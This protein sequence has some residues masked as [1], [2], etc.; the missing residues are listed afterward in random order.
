MRPVTAGTAELDLA[1][2]TLTKTGTNLV[3]FVDGSITEPGTIEINQGTL[4]LSRNTITGTGSINVNAGTTLKLENNNDNPT[5]S[6]DISIDDATLQN[7]GATLHRGLTP[8]VDQHRHHLHL[9]CRLTSPA[10]PAARVHTRP[11]PAAPGTDPL[12]QHQPQRRHH[13]QQRHCHHH[14]RRQSH[15][16]HHHHRR[17]PA[18]WQRRRPPAPSP[19]TSLNNATLRFLRSDD[20][21]FGGAIS[22]TGVLDKEGAG[23]LTLSGSG[24]YSGNTTIDLRNRETRRRQRSRWDRQQG[25]HR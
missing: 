16:R 23:T 25:Q 18:N 21:T 13:R 11:R 1:G 7:T 10:P 6:K 14:R 15:R 2:F 22:G 8:L 17:H 5:I 3:A 19:A 20:V 4:A 12:R 9:H 24:T